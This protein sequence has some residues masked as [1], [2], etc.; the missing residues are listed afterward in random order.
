MQHG[1]GQVFEDSSDQRAGRVGLHNTDSWLLQKTE[2]QSL[3]EAR[4]V[5]LA[6]YND[7]REYCKFP[8]VTSFEQITSDG[9]VRDELRDLYGHVDNIEFFVGLFAE[10]RR[11]NSVLPSMVGRLVGLHAF[12]QL[13]TNPLLAPG[14]YKHPDTFSD[15]GR[16][17]IETTKNLAQL[18]NRNLPEGSREY[19]ARLTQRDWRRA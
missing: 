1:L 3:G 15:L 9:R 16:R 10:D 2:A 19:E 17:T 6:R 4:T 12:S 8:R 13:M 18:L 11:P 5:R 7:Y 14:V